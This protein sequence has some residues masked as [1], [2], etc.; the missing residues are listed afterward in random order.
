MSVVDRYL[1]EFDLPTSLS[2][3]GELA[4]NLW[5]TWDADAKALMADIDPKRWE[6][7]KHNPVALLAGI[8]DTRLAELTD[9][10]L[11]KTRLHAIVTRF[12]EAMATTTETDLG[13]R[14][15]AY[16]CAEFGIHESLPIYSGGLGILA[17]DHLKSASDLGLP[18]VAVG[19][20]YRYGYFFQ[21]IDPVGRQVE[22]YFTNEFGM[23]PAALQCD[24][25]GKPLKIRVPMP[26]RGVDAVIWKVMVGRV[27]L[28]LLDTDLETNDVGDRLVSGHLYGGDEDTRIQQEMMLGVGG[29]RALEAV[30][31]RPDM[32]HLNEGHSA[33]LILE[34]I[35]EATRNRR[36]TLTE[37][38]A[39]VSERNV[40]TTHT[41]VA[42]GN[43]TFNV[44]HVRS[45]VHELIADTKL[46]LDAIMALGLDR[47]DDPHS[48][49]GMTVLALR[50]CRFANGVSGLHGRVARFMWKHLWPDLAEDDVPIE[51]ITNG[52]HMASWIAPEMDR[53][54]RNHLTEDG[55]DVPNETYWRLHEGLRRR[56]IDTVRKRIAKQRVRH[57]VSPTAVADAASLLNAEALTIGFAR[58]F[59]PYKRATLLLRERKRLAAL[60]NDPH[61]HVQII[62]AGK[63]H[64]RNEQGKDLMQEIWNVSQDPIFQGRI[65]LVEGYNIA[66][67]RTL[68]QGVDVW[69]NT[70]RRPLE[71]SGTSGMKAA[72]NGAPN[73][74]VDDGWWCEGYHKNNG[75][76]FGEG[77]DSQD[78]DAQDAADVEELFN[79]LENS[80]V[81]TFYDRDETGIP[82]AWVEMMKAAAMGVIPEFSSARMVDEYASRF[83]A[84]CALGV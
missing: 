23:L 26:G 33:F 13:E 73:L 53:L 43:D 81:P 1:T 66:L 45:Y 44:G 35:R 12:R 72:A 55:L 37:A 50:G 21:Q 40:F 3:L 59:A 42:A 41:P 79:L 15:A 60:L 63:A 47:P 6:A 54:Y 64:P 84:P 57:G 76:I 71:A 80:V 34:Q 67:A 19:L 11:F 24:D 17:G 65:V 31:I 38:L 46:D 61:R 62:L 9:N 74:S 14:T 8:D 39:E 28:Y 20:A 32:C 2:G 58:R 18:L 10:D 69:L 83:Y 51:H 5:W 27:P 4:R 77:A 7:V 70:P 29:L 82:Q 22:I 16:F 75:W 56:L 25:T 49:F 48:R 30:G 52:V 36:M 78:P 68:V